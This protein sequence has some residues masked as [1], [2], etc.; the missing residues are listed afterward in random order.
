MI[1]LAGWVQKRRDHGQLIFI[2]L[3]D[4]TGIVQVVFNE[5]IQK[6]A[7]KLGLEDVVEIDGEVKERPEG[8]NNDKIATGKV[9]VTAKGLKILSKAKLPPFELDK[10]TSKVDEEMRMIYRYLD[11]RSAR[12][13]QN[14]A[15]RSKIVKFIRDY[16][17]SKKFVEIETPDI[18]KGTP[19]GAREYVIPS[20]LHPGK[21]YV[22]PQSP[23]QFK[24]L[25]MIAGVERYFQIAR[26]FRDE[27]PRGDRQPEHT[28]L[29]LEMSFVKQEDIWELVEELMVSLVKKLYPNKKIT[30]IPFPRLSYQEAQNK[31]RTDKPDLREDKNNKDELAFVWIYDFPMFAK[32]ENGEITSE[33][34]PFTM[35]NEEDWSKLE[36]D[37]LKVRAY[38]YDLVLNGYE[39]ASGSIRIHKKDIQE[40]V[41]KILNLGEK[42]VKERFGH[43]LAAFEYGVPPHGGIAL[44]IDRI[45][46]VLQNE[47][48][49]REV[50]A[51]PKTGDGRDLMMGAPSDLSEKQL[52]EL[53][54]KIEK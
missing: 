19:E 39:I 15:M 47:P 53:K 45:A 43:F 24:Q 26:C 23:Q 6:E 2:D 52:K 46:M 1:K 21:F 33:H 49:I 3:R 12:M 50:I 8:M 16:M 37:P 29:D 42:E 20:R 51:F 17:I 54:I 36:K 30:A 48:S 40:K 38:S 11:L 41:F 35:P 28:Q 34:H 22:L 7:E 31:Y 27:D 10:D 14:L 13:H 25:L 9:E 18:T 5:S 32:D 4:S 44:G